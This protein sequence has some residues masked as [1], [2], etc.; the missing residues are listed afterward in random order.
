MTHSDD[1]LGDDLL[2][3]NTQIEKKI[4]VGSNF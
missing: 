3:K 2:H 1:S 4:T